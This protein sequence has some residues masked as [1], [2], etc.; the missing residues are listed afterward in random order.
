M[1]GTELDASQVP[2][3]NRHAS[4]LLRLSE[5]SRD[6]IRLLALLAVQ[7]PVAVARILA[8]ANSAAQGSS[9]VVSDMET[10]LT[11]IGSVTAYDILVKSALLNALVSKSHPAELEYLGR[12]IISLGL[13]AKRIASNSR[14]RVNFGQLTLLGAVEKLGL[15]W[16]VRVAETSPPAMASLAQVLASRRH[17]FRA[18]PALRPW[19]SRSALVAEAWGLEGALP[20]E[21]RR[22]ADEDTPLAELTD[23]ACCLLLAEQYLELVDSGMDQLERME[24]LE[25]RLNYRPAPAARVSTV[26]FT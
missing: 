8:L 23:E 10:A 2:M 14:A 20:G 1:P 15:A 12:H 6:N 22:M 4:E 19:L 26:W 7:D 24:A 13:T 16:L 21:L 5:D 11:R 25:A 3:L 9:K 18:E 17:V